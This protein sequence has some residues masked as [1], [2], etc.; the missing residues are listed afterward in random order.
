M[1]AMRPATPE[2]QPGLAA[3]IQARSD[4]MKLRRLPNWSSWGR[5]VGDLASNCTRQHGEMWVLT[6]GRGRIVGCRAGSES[7][8]PL[9]AECPSPGYGRWAAVTRISGT[10]SQGRSCSPPCSAPPAGPASTAAK[11][12]PLMSDP[13]KW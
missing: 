7:P 8:A 10:R 11:S 13:A 6:E 9:T 4:W 12:G 5:H 3:M 2:D 1:L